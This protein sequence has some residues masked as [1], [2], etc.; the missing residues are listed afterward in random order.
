MTEDLLKVTNIDGLEITEAVLIP[1]IWGNEHSGGEY[2]TT[3]R[4]RNRGNKRGSWYPY[5]TAKPLFWMLI[6]KIPTKFGV[7]CL[8]NIKIDI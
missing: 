3:Q 1:H 7:A 2:Y 8:N 4:I 5:K 6:P